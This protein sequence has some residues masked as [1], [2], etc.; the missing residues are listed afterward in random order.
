MENCSEF[1]AAAWL[2]GQI[3]NLSYIEEIIAMKQTTTLFLVILAGFLL[4]TGVARATAMAGARPTALAAPQLT[5]QP[6]AAAAAI[7]W[8]I[9]ARQ[10][11]DGGYT[12]FSSGANEQPSTVGGTVDAVLALASGGVDAALPGTGQRHSPIGYMRDHVG[13]V[14][15]YAAANG[16]NAGKLLLSLTAAAQNPRDFEGYNFVLTLTQHLSPTGQYHVSDPYNQS[17]AMLGVAA[18]RE[19]VPASAIQWLLDRQASGGDLDGSWDDGYGTLGNTDATALAVMALLAAGISPDDHSLVRAAAFLSRTQLATGGFAYAA[20]LPENANSTALALQALSALGEDFYTPGG[21]WDAGGGTPLDALFRY[22]GPTG[23]FQSDFGAGPFDDFFATVQAV[24][25]ITGRPFPLPAR[26]ESARLGLDCLA[27]LQDADTGGWEQFAGF[28]VSAAGTARAIQAIAA[29]GDDPL[30]YATPAG[31]HPLQALADLTPAY[32]SGGRGGRVGIVMQGVVAGG[33]DVTDFAG[34]NLPFHLTHYLSPTGEYDDTAFG[35]FSHA[36]ALL[37]L[38]AAR[39]S[40][41]PSAIAFLQAAQSGGNWGSPDDNGIALQSLGRLGYQPPPLALTH[42]HHTQLADGGWGYGDIANPNTTAEVV[43]GIAA[44]GQDPFDPAWSL[45]QSG[46]L[47]HAADAIM[48]TQAPG[49]C[50]LDFFGV[51]D[52]P[53]ATTDAILALTAQ[54][55][56]YPDLYLPVMFHESQN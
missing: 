20:G 51:N 32:L 45:V 9:A 53:F 10:N 8:L 43:Q 49:G 4:A 26:F 27:T 35:I 17:L 42:L 21:S 54:A 13:D 41:A 19:V 33:G 47:R 34:Y 12:S 52:D 31:I 14:A 18:V 1:C 30:D 2:R 11:R 16:G 28:G 55:W 25:G 7:N 40:P 39:Q 50:W 22:Q 6:E 37:G 46:R 38:A 5:T 15:D 29:V 48:E 56:P 44:L 36:E 3:G 23:A 24:P